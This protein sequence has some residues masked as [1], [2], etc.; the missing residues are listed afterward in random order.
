MI[1]INFMKNLKYTT[2]NRKKIIEETLRI[3]KAGGLFVFPTETCYGLGGDATNTSAI[4]RLFKYKSRREGKP[5]SIAVTDAKMASRY[6]EINE[7]GKNLYNNYLPGPIT[8]VSKSKG[9]VASGVESEY[10]TLGI[11]IPDNSLVLEIIKRFGRPITATSANISYKPKPYSIKALL[12]DTP[13][14]QL[15]LI[16][17][18]IDAGVLPRRASSTVV[19]TTLNSLNVIREGEISLNKNKSVRRP[20]L[21]AE[22]N[23]AQETVEFGGLNLLKNIDVPLKKPLVFFLDG[24]LGSGKTQFVKGI[25]TALKIKKNVKSPTFT[26]L[27][28]YAY[29][30]GERK[31]LLIHIDTWRLENKKDLESIGIDKYLENGNVLA[32]EWAG[33][34]S[35]ELK[36]KIKKKSGKI[37]KISFEYLNEHQR[38]IESY[39][40]KN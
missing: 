4:N 29:R 22:T 9:R 1:W 37:I 21:S 39:E 27:N 8:V 14:A 13:P 11:R 3:L 15:S 20:I 24:E 31:G 28:E 2:A 30:L 19:D 5:L 36:N 26:I 25:A 7:A 12:K 18:I 34:F 16:D 6:V 23:S 38:R 32:I 35:L 10:G 17:L 40:Q 33:K